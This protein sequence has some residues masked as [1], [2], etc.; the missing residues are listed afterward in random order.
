MPGN[1]NTCRMCGKPMDK[2]GR[3]IEMPADKAATTTTLWTG[4]GVT[5]L[6]NIAC[7]GAASSTDA[8]GIVMIE[9]RPGNDTTTGQANTSS[10]AATN[11]K[12]SNHTTTKAKGKK[13][14]RKA[15]KASSGRRRR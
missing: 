3:P 8:P 11:A 1:K 13:K 15:G 12:H 7:T 10:S 14:T 5:D 4:T 9:C 6:S 2:Q